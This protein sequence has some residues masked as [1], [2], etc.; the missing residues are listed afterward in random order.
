MTINHLGGELG[1]FCFDL[2]AKRSFSNDKVIYNRIVVRFTERYFLVW[3]NPGME[4]MDFL[5]WVK[6]F[7]SFGAGR[8]LRVGGRLSGGLGGGRAPLS[9]DPTLQAEP[10]PLRMLSIQLLKLVFSSSL[11]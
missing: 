5:L 2:L 6:G 1:L 3:L 8:R 11:S 10:E 9:P 4:R 7:W